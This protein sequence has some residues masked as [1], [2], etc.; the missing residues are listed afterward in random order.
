[1]PIPFPDANGDMGDNETA[2]FDPIFFFHHCFIDYT[3]S[4]WQQIHGLT[5]RGDLTLIE[6]YPGTILKVGQPSVDP[7]TQLSDDYTPSPVHIS[8]QKRFR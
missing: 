6:K 7:G 2:G 4:V 5:K 1:M 3:F 8:R